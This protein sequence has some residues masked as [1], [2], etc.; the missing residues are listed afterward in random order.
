MKTSLKTWNTR[1]QYDKN[2]NKREM[3]SY[4]F[5]FQLIF[6]QYFPYH[7]TIQLTFL[8]YF[9]YIFTIQ[10]TFLLHFPYLFTFELTFLPYIPH[11]VTIFFRI[12]KIFSLFNFLS[13]IFS[14]FFHY[15]IYL[16]FGSEYSFWPWAL[17]VH[18]LSV[19]QEH[20]VVGSECLLENCRFGKYI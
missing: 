4:L 2:S 20:I 19:L 1:K 8:S 18:L 3:F 11:H 17:A 5:T 13:S 9:P 14:V 15:S 6:F 12:F 10:P 16:S 7:F